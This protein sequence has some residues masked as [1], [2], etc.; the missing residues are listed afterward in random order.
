MLNKGS[1][2]KHFSW[3]REQVGIVC[4]NSNYDL[5]TEATCIVPHSGRANMGSLIATRG[6]RRLVTH[7][8]HIFNSL[9]IMATRAMI[10]AD[11][12]PGGLYALFATPSGTPIR[13]ITQRNNQFLPSPVGHPNLLQRWDFYLRHELTQTNHDRLRALIAQ[14]LNLA[15]PGANQLGQNGDNP[16]RT[17][18]AIR[19]ECIEADAHANPPQTQTIL[20]SDEYDLLN[21]DADDSGLNFTSAYSKIVLVTSPTA[22]PT[23][24]DPQ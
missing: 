20:Q 4:F 19:F 9:Q 6:T 21:H 17:Y 3:T 5:V 23:P 2:A 1:E 22:S 10:I 24:R 15:N 8:N 7:Y 16:S 13:D 14:A 18:T 12:A 11:N